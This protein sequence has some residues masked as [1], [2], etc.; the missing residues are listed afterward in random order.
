MISGSFLHNSPSER[1]RKH[2]AEEGHETSTGDPTAVVV[3]EV[4]KRA[5]GPRVR[6]H[7]FCDRNEWLT[8]SQKSNLH[9]VLRRH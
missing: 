7:L 8:Y 9:T 6:I 5:A 2:E 3:H 1:G 4:W